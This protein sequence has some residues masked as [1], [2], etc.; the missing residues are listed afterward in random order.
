M[1]LQGNS[2]L[3]F[4]RGSS[5]SGEWMEDYDYVNLESKEAVNKQNAEIRE[6]LPTQLR[7]SYDTLIQEAERLAVS[8]DKKL[9]PSVDPSDM[10]VNNFRD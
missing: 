9:D 6:A 7:K 4:K 2:T 8:N 1:C 10:Q 3:L 5:P